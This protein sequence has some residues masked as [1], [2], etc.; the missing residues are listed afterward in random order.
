MI[1]TPSCR[2]LVADA[3]L[4][5]AVFSRFTRRRVTMTTGLRPVSKASDHCLT[6]VHSS[7]FRTGCMESNIWGAAAAIICLRQPAQRKELAGQEG[8]TSCHGSFRNTGYR[9]KRIVERGSADTVQ[10]QL[11]HSQH[12][13]MKWFSLGYGAMNL[14]NAD[15]T[16]RARLQAARRRKKLFP[17][18]R[19]S[20]HW[21]SNGWKMAAAAVSGS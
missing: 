7:A 19:S 13:F 16:D 3:V 15:S 2:R 20:H 11:V 1:E 6:Q 8:S 5:A 17:A 12:R 9:W 4:L 21:G 10:Q 18:S 14:L